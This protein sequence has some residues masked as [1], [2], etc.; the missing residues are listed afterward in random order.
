M[1]VAQELKKKSIAEYLLYMWQ[2]EDIIRACGCSLPVIKKHYIEILISL[3]NR[4]RRKST[5]LAI[6]SA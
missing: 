2:V 3:R 5:G 1:F 4:R 6:S